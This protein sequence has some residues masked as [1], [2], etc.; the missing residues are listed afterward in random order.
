MR[1]TSSLHVCCEG[2]R[3]S[4]N[5]GNTNRASAYINRLRLESDSDVKKQKACR[6]SGRPGYR[7]LDFGRVWTEKSSRLSKTT[8]HTDAAF[9]SC[10]LLCFLIFLL[11]ASSFLFL[12]IIYYYLTQRSRPAVVFS[13][14]MFE[15]QL[16]CWL[17]VSNV[18]VGV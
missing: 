13:I 6:F 12:F 5:H 18:F 8:A 14:T 7:S 1:G 4:R 9:S 15:I 3:A 17:H 16:G 2:K 11:P 10:S